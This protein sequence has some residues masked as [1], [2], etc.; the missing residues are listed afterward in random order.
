MQIHDI[1]AALTAHAVPISQDL[2]ASPPAVHAGQQLAER[3]VVGE[4][5]GGGGMADVFRGHDLWLCRDVAIKVLKQGIASAEMCARMLQEGRAAAAID[6]PHLLRMLDIGRVGVT[7]YLITELLHGCSLAEHLRAAPD[8]RV[9]WTRA[10]ELLLPALDALQRVHDRGYIHRDLKPDNLFIHQRDGRAA[11]IVLDLGIAKVAPGLRPEGAPHTT[12]SGRVLGTPAYMSPEQASSLP[13]DY[14]TDIYSIGVTLHRMLAGRLP[15]ETRGGEGP[16]VLMAHHIYDAP[17]RLDG[18]LAIPAKL[19]EVVLRAMAKAPAGRPQSMKEFAEELRGCLVGAAPHEVEPAMPTRAR[20]RGSL[21]FLQLGSRHL[22]K[23][24]SGAAVVAT[25]L[26]HGATPEAAATPAGLLQPGPDAQP[27]LYPE[28]PARFTLAASRPVVPA[29]PAVEH[30]P[31]PTRSTKRDAGGVASVLAGAA[32]PVA[33][34]I[35]GHGGIEV[36]QV[37][38]T[39]TV[40]SGGMVVRSEFHDSDHSVLSGCIRPVLRA[41]KFAP[42]PVQQVVHAFKRTEPARVR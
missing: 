16:Y 5:I 39:L 9:P 10:I 29:M 41:L 22:G 24:A 15:F 34:C 14:R 38:A 6:H 12:G 13:L 7:V 28:P 23:A 3:Y 31:S 11:L 20:R 8:G 35:R 21:G 30:P 25:L 17:P 18:A 26:L 32:A 37:S 4:R 27:M 42:G 33:R 36:V 1:H 40:N 2:A 19:A